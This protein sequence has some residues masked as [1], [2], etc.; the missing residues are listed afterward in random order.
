LYSTCA[1]SICTFVLHPFDVKGKRINGN[2][3]LY[4][5]E[6]FGEYEDEA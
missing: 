2:D 3:G 4:D 5:L 1:A 6:G